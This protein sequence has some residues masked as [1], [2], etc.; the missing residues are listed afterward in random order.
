MQYQKLVRDRIA[1]IIEHQGKKPITHVANEQEYYLKL[2]EKLQE[3][4]KE[5]I[6]TDNIEELGDLL[7]VIYAIC[8]LKN[9]TREQLENLRRKKN[10]ERG[11]FLSRIILDEIQS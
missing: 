2:K 7:E 6:E 4:V 11:K 5:Y 9:I 8:D 1:K 3:E 10:L